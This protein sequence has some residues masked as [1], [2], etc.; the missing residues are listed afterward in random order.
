MHLLA[1]RG[2]AGVAGER[3]EQQPGRLEDPAT[4]RRVPIGP[5]LVAAASPP[6]SAPTTTAASDAS[7]TATMTRVTNAVLRTPR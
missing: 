4:T 3:E 5:R 6:K 2:D 1:E 7:T